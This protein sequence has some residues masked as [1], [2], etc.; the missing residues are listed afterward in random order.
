MSPALAFIGILVFLALGASV[1]DLTRE[2]SAP[3]LL[4]LFGSI[5]LLVVVFAHI[6]EVFHLFPSMGWGLPNSAGHYID[7]IS[8]V[9]GPILFATGYV[10][11]RLVKQRTS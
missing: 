11:R 3:A 1:I 10:W 4:Q 9:G 5:L 7:L 8:A 2:K 6:A